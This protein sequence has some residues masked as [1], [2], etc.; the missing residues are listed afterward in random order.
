MIPTDSF[1][2]RYVGTVAA[3][4]PQPSLIVDIVQ[5]S[6]VPVPVTCV[7][8]FPSAGHGRISS[9]AA[10]RPPWLTCDYIKLVENFQ[11]VFTVI[12]VDTVGTANPLIL[13]MNVG[14]SN[15]F[16]PIC[17]ICKSSLSLLKKQSSKG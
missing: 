17:C 1:Q 6:A 3:P 9:H 5:Y 13:K 2:S 16:N 15:R 7:V 12:N 11:F 4:P 8:S 14:S 10:T